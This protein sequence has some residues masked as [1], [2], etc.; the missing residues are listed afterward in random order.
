MGERPY[1]VLSC[2]VS[3]DGYLDDTSG[4]RLLVSGDTDLDRVDGVRASCDAILVGAGTVR[5]DDPRLR[6]RDPARR[7]DRVARGDTATPARVTVTGTG[8]LDP[9]ARFFRDDAERLVYCEGSA[10]ASVARRLGSLATVIDGGR[11]LTM[12]RVGIELADR[13]VRRLLVE[14]GGRV[15]TQFLTAGLADELQLAVAAFFVGDSRAPRFVGDG[16]FPWTCGRR[17]RLVAACP[18]GEVV[19]LRYALG[20]RYDE[21]HP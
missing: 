12:E 17:A 9:S 20:D 8:R 5:A 11:P 3:L 15:L 2:G 7:K 1:T 13:G 16:D 21:E 4:R 18:V 6:V 14:G 10:V 19:L